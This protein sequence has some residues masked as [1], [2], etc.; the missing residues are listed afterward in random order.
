MNRHMSAGHTLRYFASA[1]TRRSSAQVEES[2]DALPSN[3]FG[4]NGIPAMPAIQTSGVFR[5]PLNQ[6][7]GAAEGEYLQEQEEED[8]GFV[9]DDVVETVLNDQPIRRYDWRKRATS[10]LQKNV[11]LSALPKGYKRRVR[12]TPAE[13]ISEKE[14]ALRPAVRNYSEKYAVMSAMC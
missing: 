2:D 9:E 6:S 8:L 3:V 10:R 14:L 13:F 5:P 1:A 12:K 7:K 11:D 4:T